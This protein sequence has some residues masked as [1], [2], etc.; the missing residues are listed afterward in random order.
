[1]NNIS[2]DNILKK[3]TKCSKPWH[4]TN[5]EVPDYDVLVICAYYTGDNSKFN[6][7]KGYCISLAE[8]VYM[9]HSDGMKEDMWIVISNDLKLDQ[10][11]DACMFFKNN[12]SM[13]CGKLQSD[14]L[15]EVLN[16]HQDDETT[17]DNCSFLETVQNYY[18]NLEPATKP[19]YWMYIPT[20]Y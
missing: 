9:T 18:N 15:S 16:D 1:M 14:N 17:Y 13:S 2:K 3:L 10:T 5:D 7:L 19:D 6:P 11:Y 20:L 8:R 4:C 12:L